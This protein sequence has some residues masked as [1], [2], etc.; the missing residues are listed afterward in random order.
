[1]VQCLNIRLVK[2][3]FRSK[4]KKIPSKLHTTGVIYWGFL[5]LVLQRREMIEYICCNLRAWD[6]QGVISILA[7]SSV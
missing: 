7:V 5:L 3:N 2:V 4:R 6:T 1:M